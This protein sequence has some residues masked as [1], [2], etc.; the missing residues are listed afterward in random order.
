[1]LAIASTRA[2]KTMNVRDRVPR[3]GDV[4]SRERIFT[5][6]KCA[7]VSHTNENNGEFDDLLQEK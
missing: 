4:N 7:S 2:F 6:L 5:M 1:M 3:A